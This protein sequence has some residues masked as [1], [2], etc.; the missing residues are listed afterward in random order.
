[1]NYFDHIFFYVNLFFFF[2]TVSVWGCCSFLENNQLNIQ[3]WALGAMFNSF[4]HFIG[5]NNQ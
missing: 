4:G 1:M 3:H 5:I 2:F